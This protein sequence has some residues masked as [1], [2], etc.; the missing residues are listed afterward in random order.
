MMQDAEKRA[1]EQFCVCTW[2]TRINSIKG[3]SF[4]ST[5]L[6]SEKPS[7][8]VYHRNGETK[9]W[10]YRR[11]TKLSAS[12]I[13]PVFLLRV[14]SVIFGKEGFLFPPRNP[15]QIKWGRKKTD[16]RFFL[17]FSSRTHFKASNSSIRPNSTSTPHTRRQLSVTPAALL[18]LS[19]SS[20]RTVPEIRLLLFP[21][22]K[23]LCT[24]FSF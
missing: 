19:H 4:V 13:T 24:A 16:G 15:E 20:W 9:C 3:A 6:L 12:V 14:S 1:E 22:W 7:E 23:V 8:L 18:D 2:L 17:L 5:A 21:L 11:V 10:F